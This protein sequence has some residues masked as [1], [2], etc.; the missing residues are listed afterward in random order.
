VAG[1]GIGEIVGGLL[2][3]GF[4][5]GAEIVDDNIQIAFVMGY[6]PGSYAC[7]PEDITESQ[8]KLDIG[9]VFGHTENEAAGCDFEGDGGVEMFE[10]KG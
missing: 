6:N 4:H 1:G 9:I 7:I 3:N 8:Y 2:Y 5:A 10:N